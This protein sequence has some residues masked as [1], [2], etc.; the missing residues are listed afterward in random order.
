MCIRDR[1]T[2]AQCIFPAAVLQNPFS[3]L[4]SQIQSVKV[5]ILIFQEIHDTKRLKIVLKTA[6]ISHAAVERC[7]AGVTKGRVAQVVRQRNRFR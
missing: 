7:V 6:E 5:R 4:P 2:E 1:S 3:G